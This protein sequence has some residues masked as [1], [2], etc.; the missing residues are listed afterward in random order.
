MI[1]P[2]ATITSIALVVGDDGSGPVYQDQT[3]PAPAPVPCELITLSARRVQS[4]AANG[5]SAERSLLVL[6][7][8]IKRITGEALASAIATIAYS[9]RGNQITERLVIV[10]TEEEP[11]EGAMGQGIVELLARTSNDSITV[12]PAGGA[13]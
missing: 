10:R 6:S 4:L 2:N 5:I 3:L 13:P 8:D 1:R 12:L 9:R 11:P 7:G